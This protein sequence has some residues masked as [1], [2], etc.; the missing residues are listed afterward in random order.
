MSTAPV[1]KR[2]G[3]KNILFLT[4]FSESSAMALPFAAIIA[5]SYGAKVCQGYGTARP[6]SVRLQ[7]YDA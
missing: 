5:R 2:I 4:D 6:R 1:S 7:L 3:V